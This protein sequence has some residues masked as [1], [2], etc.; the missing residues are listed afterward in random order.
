MSHALLSVTG[1]AQF[2]RLHAGQI[3]RPLLCQRLL[4]GDY[5]LRLLCAPAGSGKSLLLGECLAQC[6]KG[7]DLTYLDLRGAATPPERLRQL[8]AQ[9][10]GGSDADPDRLEAQLGR[11]AR[12]LWLVL[13]DY[14]RMPDA[15]LDHA[16]NELLLGSSH[17]VRWWIASR[18]RP[19]LQLER[20]LLEDSLLEL[21]ADDL[22]FSLTELHAI[23]KAR[24]LNWPATAVEKL[25][26]LSRGWCAGIRL[27]LLNQIPGQEPASLALQT[28]RLLGYLKREV[29]DELPE[30]WRQALFTLALL[31]HFDA[32]LCE[33]LLGMGEGAQH[34]TQLQNCGLFIGSDRQARQLFQ[35]QPMVAQALAE[36]LP[37][38]LAKA[39]FRRACHWYINQGQLRP[40]MEY[41]IRADQPEVAVSL[42]E[43]CSEDF[44]LQGR[45]LAQLLKWQDQLP[46]ELLCS[47]PRLV[48]LN[49]W[50]LLFSGRLDEAQAY[51]AHL[52]VFLPPS[53]ATQQQALLGQWQA[54][55]ACLA[56]HR[57]HGPQARTHLEAALTQL[58]AQA[59]GTR[60]MCQALQLEQSLVE[61]QFDNARQLNRCATRHAREHVSQAMESVL[62]LGHVKLLE[63]R[64]E[65][66]RA[67]SLLRRLQDE[68]SS[69]WHGEA[70]PMRGRTH[71]RLGNLLLQLGRYPEAESSFCAG[72]TEAQECGDPAAVWA[73]LGLAELAAR[74]GK[75]TCAFNHIADGERLMQCRH[76]SE[77][78]YRG[79]LLR[80]RARLWL[81]Q[82]RSDLA[83][84][85]LLAEPLA[86]LPPY[87]APDLHLQLRLLLLRAQLANGAIDQA[88]DG[89]HS[90]HDQ[91][92]AEGRQVLAC[93]IGFSL[94][95]ALYASN[96]SGQG[97][98][99]LL[100]AIGQARRMNLVDSERSF[101]RR[102]PTLIQALNTRQQPE[103]APV[104]L[105]SRR[106]LEVLKLI[107]R[108]HSNQQIAE[109]LFISLH[110]VKTHTQHIH[111]KLGVERRTQ[112]IAKAKELGL[113]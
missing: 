19:A 95:E 85:S 99:Y 79:L 67:E 97:K 6:P 46:R 37:A 42:M 88:R 48:L 78:L 41:A 47:T 73:Y 29:L 55:Q 89:L 91:A 9:A 81:L 109:S 26:S 51:S 70:S 10:L 44:I 34:L 101:A 90:L 104:A 8:L 3:A 25:H 5:R 64:G 33:Q 14:P 110:T 18:R 98:Q 87:G 35:L 1:P 62:V 2:P 74:Q 106:E 93:E 103:E 82:G 28:E 30:E 65:L 21:Q 24:G 63:I 4:E 96:R 105:L 69:V 113:G 39:A 66:L 49:A 59:W 27:H 72:L 100:E 17:Q 84:H 7:T 16:L 60:L 15:S 22:A 11:L 12:P 80:T 92:R 107:V 57:G 61:G 75:L 86:A 58:P 50:V 112:A 38:S 94:A 108:G 45:S 43:K 102:C 56:Y 83:E 77:S 13:D 23:L 76:V 32:G 68:L 71:L 36:Q 53:T 31:P 40:A 111:S 20:L 54:L 52:A